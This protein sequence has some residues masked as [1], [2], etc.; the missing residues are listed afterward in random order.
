MLSFVSWTY[1]VAW[2]FWKILEIRFW[3]FEIVISMQ[4]GWNKAPNFLGPQLRVNAG[5]FFL[6]QHW[7]R[8]GVAKAVRPRLVA[9]CLSAVHRRQ[10]LLRCIMLLIG[11]TTKWDRTVA[12]AESNLFLK[13]KLTK[14]Y[15]HSTLRWETLNDLVTIAVAPLETGT[16]EKINYEFITKIFILT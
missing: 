9:S 1:Q 4:C 15:L 6:R 11:K 3:N 16:L 8:F 7:L 2:K 12:L 5:G 10:I 14:S 13:L